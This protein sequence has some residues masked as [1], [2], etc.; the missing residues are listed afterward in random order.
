MRVRQQKGRMALTLGATPFE[1]GQCHFLVWAPHAKSVE[2]RILDPQD[3]FS[4]TAAEYP[5]SH[6]GERLIRLDALDRGYHGSTV[7]GVEPGTQYVY[8]LDRKKDRPDPASLFQPTGVHGP[9]QV[10]DPRTFR[11][12]DADWRGH[13]PR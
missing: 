12:S 6:R 10:V 8:C 7:K 3:S 1:G 2:V 5:C 11:W 4:A 9:S 13:P